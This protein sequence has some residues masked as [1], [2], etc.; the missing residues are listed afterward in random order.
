MYSLGVPD[1]FEDSLA[2]LN[3]CNLHRTHFLKEDKP[4]TS[5]LSQTFQDEVNLWFLE[6]TEV[7]VLWR[8]T[9]SNFI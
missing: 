5:A 7:N 8:K 2:L 3:N 9:S 6:E 4:G 1:E